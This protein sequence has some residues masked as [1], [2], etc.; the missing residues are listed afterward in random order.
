MEGRAGEACKHARAAGDH[1]GVGTARRVYAKARDNATALVLL[2]LGAVLAMGLMWG[3]ACQRAY[4]DGQASGIASAKAAADQQAYD[5]G[6]AAAVYEY[7]EG[8]PSWA[9]E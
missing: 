8:D 3:Q 1:A 6:Y 7:Q 2:A 9:R 5:R 4:L